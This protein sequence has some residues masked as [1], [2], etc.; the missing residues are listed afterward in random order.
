MS[1]SAEKDLLID[2]LLQERDELYLELSRLRDLDKGI[3]WEK[4][5]DKAVELEKIIQEKDAVIQSGERMIKS[6]K[7]KIR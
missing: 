2:T 1:D 5:E 6:K 3:L 4:A 7:K